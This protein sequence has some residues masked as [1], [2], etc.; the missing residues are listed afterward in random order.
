MVKENIQKKVT[1]RIIKFIEKGNLSWLKGWV[2]GLPQN[3]ISKKNYRG[4][5]AILIRM[6]MLENNF[7]QPYYLTFRQVNQMKGKVNVN[8]SGEMVVYLDFKHSFKREVCEKCNYIPEDCKCGIP[9]DKIKKITATFQAPLLRAYT[10]F[11]VEQTDL[12][13]EDVKKEFNPIEKCEGIVKSYKDIPEIVDDPA[14]AYYNPRKDVIGMP[15][16]T[17]FNGEVEY[18]PVIFHEMIHSTGH[19]DRLNRKGVVES[20][21][22]GGEK[23]SE[24]E[25]IAE[26]GGAF[27]C[28][29]AGIE[30]NTLKNS[31]AYIKHWLDSL[32]QDSSFIFKVVG[33]SQRAVDW[34]LG[35][36]FEGV[37]K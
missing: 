12:K 10:V 34:I 13:I 3:Y 5:N 37:S 22:F 28:A 11:N 14:S 30:N 18:Y 31:S 19:K 17:K 6:H 27:L 32:K 16:K 1:D 20:D 2:S 33:Q 26:L 25:V 15:N 24:E 36:K 23:Y 8:A 21:F 4:I 29:E 9:K 7:K 35:K